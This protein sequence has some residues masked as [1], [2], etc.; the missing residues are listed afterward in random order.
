MNP[1][2]TGAD[3]D[4]QSSIEKP[5][6]DQSKD[7]RDLEMREGSRTTVPPT[8]LAKDLPPMPPP[9]KLDSL[10]ATT[11]VPTSP[12]EPPNRPL[13]PKPVKLSPT[14][15]TPQPSR[16]PPSR[17][18]VPLGMNPPTRPGTANSWRS[19]STASSS[20]GFPVST[21]PTSWTSGVSKRPLKYAQGRYGRIELVPQP[22]D[23]PDDPLN[24]PSWR[25]ELHFYSLL[26][27]VAMTGV[28][29][30]MFMTVNAQIADIY[31]VSYTAVAALTG[32]PLIL[33]ALAGLACL[34]T[35]RICG[36]RPLYLVS[37]LCLFIGTVWSTSVTSNYAQCMAAR[38]FQGLA[39]GAFDT[40]VLGSI[41]DTYF[42][43]ERGL[44]V[45]I[46]SIVATT[47]VWG[48]PLIGGA[49][50][51]GPSGF[52]LQPTILSAFFVVT[53]PAIA[54]GV[55][56]TAYDRTPP[57]LQTPSTSNSEFKGST[58]L[59]P[60]RVPLLEAIADYMVKLKP[61]AYSSKADLRT[62]L[63]APRAF[64]T[65]TTTMLALV[66]LLPYGSLWGL[67][68]SLS[69]LFYPLPFML[70]PAVIGVIFLSPFLLSSAA[71]AATAF[72][73]AWQNR[74]APRM[75]MVAIAAASAIGLTGLLTFGLHLNKAMTPPPEA[76]PSASGNIPTP[77]EQ[78]SHTAIRTSVFALS[79][80]GPRANLPACSF[81]LGLLAAAAALFHATAA[82]LIRAS[83]SFTAANLAVAT[84]ITVDMTGGL[85]FWQAL[86]AGIF[87][88]G[89]P[90]AVWW[91][92]GLKAFCVGVGAAQAAVAAAVG[93]VWWFC[94]DAIRRW[95][96]RVMGLVDLE[97]LKRAGSFFDMD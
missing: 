31:K 96:G 22:S 2:G 51:Q 20:L 26:M 25:K 8:P 62:L 58:P 46:H 90:N 32:I 77:E 66:S 7:T 36:K 23:D 39:W 38:V 85:A 60:R 54:L 57:Y 40:L 34:V 35:S 43:H 53:V 67:T 30:T 24:W 27:G 91:W 65:P 74:F 33:S 15:T 64:I 16:P 56:E 72:L 52:S 41:Q 63:Q 86:G 5:S 79:Y 45:A 50:S 83:T 48:P 87:V 21:T 14:P 17:P 29:K 69:L 12:Y 18:Q 59:T 73:P 10:G 75:H 61:K 71:T 19:G 95:D 94:G 92:D 55:P 44:R 49:A 84:R 88:M 13:P 76:S 6:L 78:G 70:S 28:T 97:G 42:D 4:K 3:T 1:L 81:A 89:T 68:A 80:L 9:T 82:P 93:I 11:G 47:T 37:L